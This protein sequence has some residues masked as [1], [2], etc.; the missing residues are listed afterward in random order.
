MK[1]TGLN[2]YT[3]L[4]SLNTI[5]VLVFMK[6]KGMGSFDVICLLRG[7]EGEGLELSTMKQL[8]S[9]VQSVV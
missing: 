4:V 2:S 5:D 3:V 8:L 6:S 7:P 9:W 1:Y